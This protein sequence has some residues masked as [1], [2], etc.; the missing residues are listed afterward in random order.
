MRMVMDKESRYEYTNEIIIKKRPFKHT[1]STKKKISASKKGCSN[2]HLQ[3]ANHQTK[4]SIYRRISDLKE[5]PSDLAKEYGV[6]R[7]TIYRWVNE[8]KET[9]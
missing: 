6:S 3:K 9:L 7:Q 1:Q 4:V 2:S 5:K 8:I